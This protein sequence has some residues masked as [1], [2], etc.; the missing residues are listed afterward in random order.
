[1]IY[2]Q[3]KNGV[4]VNTIILEDEALVNKFSEGFD[5]LARIDNLEVKPGIGWAFDGSSFIAPPQ[6]EITE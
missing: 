1:M 6:P 5:Q 3:I 4:V 2:V